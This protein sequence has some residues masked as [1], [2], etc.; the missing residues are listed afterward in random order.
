MSNQR[1]H[2]DSV[3]FDTISDDYDDGGFAKA[4]NI[5]AYLQNMEAAGSK[6]LAEIITKYKSSSN[7]VDC[8]AYDSFL[9]W[10]LDVAKYFDL[11][12]ASFSTQA[13]R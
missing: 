5:H 2:S 10:A 4:E 8:L 3:Q 11:F 13:C 9:Y 7:P 12:A 6:T 1:C